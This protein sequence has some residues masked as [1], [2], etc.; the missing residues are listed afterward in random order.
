[1]R[2]KLI[3]ELSESKPLPPNV[4]C[5]PTYCILEPGFNRV[6]VG[7]RNVLTKSITIPSRAVVGQLQ[8][9]KVVT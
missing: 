3:A 1:M 9:T 8:H 5:A 4:Q 7:L 6:A 2:L